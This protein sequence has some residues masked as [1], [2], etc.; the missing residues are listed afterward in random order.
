MEEVI[1]SKLIA[2]K[3]GRYTIYVFK[4]LDSE[5]NNYIM[6]TRLPNWKC[7]EVFLNDTGYLQTLTVEAGKEY[8]NV[9]TNKIEKYQYSNIYFKNFMKESI[10]VKNNEIII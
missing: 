6:C 1:F 5:K 10:E 4:N 2:I 3:E 8:F 9:Q 7:P